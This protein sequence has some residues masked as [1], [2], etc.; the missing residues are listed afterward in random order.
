M[1]IL[2]CE[3][4]LKTFFSVFNEVLVLP[5]VSFV[6]SRIF[7]TSLFVKDPPLVK[8]SATF[9]LTKLGTIPPAAFSILSAASS[10][11]SFPTLVFDG[12]RTIPPLAAVFNPKCLCT[13][14]P[15]LSI[16]SRLLTMKGCLL[17][18]TSI[19]SFLVSA[20]P[21]G[22]LYKSVANTDS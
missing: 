19:I 13:S 14:L 4:L 11:T 12:G 21:I 7:K 18:S 17:P 5:F 2:S 3:I 15:V 1:L 9:V 16:L 8:K 10:L 6:S 20:G 22:V